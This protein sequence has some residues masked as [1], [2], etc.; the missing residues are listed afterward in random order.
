METNADGTFFEEGDHVR[1]K[2]TGETGRINATDGG[3][4]YVLM[5]ETNETALFSAYVDEDTSI[6]L[7]TAEGGNTLHQKE[8]VRRDVTDKA[9][10]PMEVGDTSAEE[11]QAA[12]PTV[13][14]SYECISQVH[15]RES[16]SYYY[17]VACSI[18]YPVASS[19]LS[20]RITG[21]NTYRN[22]AAKE[23][24]FTSHKAGATTYLELLEGEHLEVRVVEQDGTYARA[25]YYAHGQELT[26]QNVRGI[27][28]SIQCIGVYQ[29]T[30][31]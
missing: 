30:S 23:V 31:Y 11:N 28:S 21:R 19:H 6:E 15:M 12:L 26:E 9:G 22:A 25:F 17:E 27:V 20:I 16:D 13:R 24:S 4:V 18:S 2:R 5:D 10:V 29:F 7:V 8:G 1:V 14:I 3:V